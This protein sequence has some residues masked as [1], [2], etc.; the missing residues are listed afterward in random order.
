MHM[1]T[2]YLCATDTCPRM[3]GHHVR[4]NRTEMVEALNI[5]FICE[6]RRCDRGMDRRTDERTD[7][8]REEVSYRN[9]PKT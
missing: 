9:D 4:R 2:Y 3:Y 7:T 5:K 1:C 8:V 6:T